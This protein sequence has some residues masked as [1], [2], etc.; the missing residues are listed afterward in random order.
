MEGKEGFLL[1]CNIIHT[2]KK[3]PKD[4]IGEL[5][6][7]ILEYVNDMNPEVND[8]NI[9]LVFE[10]I[11]QSLKKDLI[12]YRAKC[13]K[14]K[15]NA[16]IRWG[17]KNANA[18]ERIHTEIPNANDADIDI[19]IDIGIDIDKDIN[20]GK[21]INKDISMTED[22]FELF[23]LKYPKKQDKKKAKEKFLRLNSEL[24]ETIMYALD[25]QT[26][27]KSWKEGYI[28]YPTTWLN[29][30]RW[31]DEVEQSLELKTYKELCD[32]NTKDRT[33]FSQYEQ[34]DKGNSKSMWRLK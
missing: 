21:N 22:M 13:E 28:P 24:F 33:I 8:L 20:K 31:D 4:K 15:E 30:E 2:V 9:A 14:N 7:T 11:K 18:S 3:L 6:I 29:G 26:Q 19:D 17:K 32:L 23:W 27:S 10:P 16:E 34:V 25:Y 1:Y 5:F 12:K